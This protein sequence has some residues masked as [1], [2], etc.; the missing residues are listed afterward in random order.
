MNKLI[1]SDYGVTISYNVSNCIV[2][3]FINCANDIAHN[4]GLEIKTP[5]N[6]SLPVK[7]GYE[8]D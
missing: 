6:E 5:I 2:S 3:K 1:K 7:V 8:H 4:K